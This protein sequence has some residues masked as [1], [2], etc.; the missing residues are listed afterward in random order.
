MPLSKGKI[1][2]TIAPARFCENPDS[3]GFLLL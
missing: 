1:G 2:L 3:S